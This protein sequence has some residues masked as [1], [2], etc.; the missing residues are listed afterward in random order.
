[1][2]QLAD[3]RQIAGLRSFSRYSARE[4]L[5][6]MQV[7]RR[8]QEAFARIFE[9][10]D[11]LVAPARL[12]IAPKI[13]EPLDRPAGAIGASAT[14]G[15]GVR[16]LRSI[17]PAGNLAGLPAL[18]LPCGYFSGMPVGLQLV[19]RPFSE[20]TLLQLGIQFQKTSGWHRKTPQN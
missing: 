7:R 19:G 6:A 14:T 20:N 11:V 18:V 2:D 16:G 13:S 17:I 4:Y 9:E 15:A 3:E 12:D 8:V 10:F 5:Q 1:V